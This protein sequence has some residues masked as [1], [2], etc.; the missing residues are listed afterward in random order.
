MKVQWAGLEAAIRGGRGSVPL[1]LWPGWVV[2]WCSSW[3]N[4]ML[5]LGCCFS[6]LLANAASPLG[7]YR[8]FSSLVEMLFAPLEIHLKI[9]TD[10]HL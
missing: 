6:Y 10:A 9:P 2:G 4:C 7:G 8:N 5:S 1:V 3:S